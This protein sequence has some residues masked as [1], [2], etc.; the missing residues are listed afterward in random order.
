MINHDSPLGKERKRSFLSRWLSR[1]FEQKKDLNRDET[2]LSNQNFNTSVSDTES[3]AES[4][5]DV[6]I[7][8][9]STSCLPEVI[10]KRLFAQPECS[11]LDGLNEYDDDFTGFTPRGAL[12]TQD[13]VREYFRKESRN[14]ARSE[15]NT[16]TM[17]SNDNG[18]ENSGDRLQKDLST[19]QIDLDGGSDS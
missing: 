15:T 2:A 8:K 12:L 7:S 5:T 1:K 3:H 4:T 9:Q 14:T 18:R 19:A 16:Q 13:M 11:V 17:L 6:P 10:I